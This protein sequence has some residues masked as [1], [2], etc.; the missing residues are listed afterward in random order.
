MTPLPIISY[1]PSLLAVI[2]CAEAGVHPIAAGVI[3][4]VAGRI[5]VFQPCAG[6]ASVRQKG[7]SA[8]TWREVITANAAESPVDN[9]KK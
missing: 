2:F 7:D 6:D 3:R 4:K 1:N 9:F 5:E 8:R